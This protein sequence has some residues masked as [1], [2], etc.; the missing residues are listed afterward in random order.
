VAEGIALPDSSLIPAA[1]GKDAFGH[2]LAPCGTGVAAGPLAEGVAALKT[3]DRE[4]HD[5]MQAMGT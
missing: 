5:L 1:A 2:R 3:V 4:L